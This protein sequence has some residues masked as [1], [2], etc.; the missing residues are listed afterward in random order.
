MLVISKSAP[1]MLP[2]GT[3]EITESGENA[4]IDLHFLLPTG[5]KVNH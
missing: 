1:R 4:V 3:P 2:C 5:E